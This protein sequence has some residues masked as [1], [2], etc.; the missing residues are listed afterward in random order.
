VTGVQTCA[1]PIYWAAAEGGLIGY[2][3]QYPDHWTQGET[4][5]ELEGMLKSL[6]DDIQQFD[7]I[8]SVVSCRTGKLVFQA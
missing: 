6:Y 1:L 5:E 3:Q 2:L 7:D 4:L 8:Q